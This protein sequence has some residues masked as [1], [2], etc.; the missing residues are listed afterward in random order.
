M[1]GVLLQL[2]SDYAKKKKKSFICSSEYILT[3]EDQCFF[4]GE[5]VFQHV[6]PETSGF[7]QIEKKKN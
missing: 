6:T 2:V 4:E 5:V 3:T 7:S 1:G